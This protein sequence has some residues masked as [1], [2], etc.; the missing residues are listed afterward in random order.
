MTFSIKAKKDENEKQTL[1]QRGEDA[2]KL[3]NHQKLK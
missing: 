2:N 3:K 1:F